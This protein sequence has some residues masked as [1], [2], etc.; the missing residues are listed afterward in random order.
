[1]GPFGACMVSYLPNLKELMLSK[2]STIQEGTIS[3]TWDSSIWPISHHWLCWASVIYWA[4]LAENNITGEGL[5]YIHRLCKLK[6]LHLCNILVTQKTTVSL[7][8]EPFT[9]PNR[10]HWRFSS[11]VC[12]SM[13]QK[14]TRLEIMGLTLWLNSAHSKNYGFILIKSLMGRSTNSWG[15][16]N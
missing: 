5:R 16:G 3:G 15:W 6:T 10:P 7:T 4:T 1:M 14:T 13:M 12:V 8:K 2:W 11:Y 9:F